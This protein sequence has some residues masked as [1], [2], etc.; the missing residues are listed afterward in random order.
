MNPL[1]ASAHEAPERLA[2]KVADGQQI[3]FAHFQDLADLGDAGPL[4]QL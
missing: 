4:Q 1:A 2:A 3:V